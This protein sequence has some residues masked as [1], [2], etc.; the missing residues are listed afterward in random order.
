L[1]ILK[2][3]KQ[4]GTLYHFTTID[5]FVDIIFSEN[6]ISN[7]DLEGKNWYFV[8]FGKYPSYEE[9]RSWVEDMPKD[10]N[11]YHSLSFT[12]DK[13]L[14]KNVHYFN[15]RRIRF[16]FD[17]DKIS[18]KYRIVPFTDSNIS[19]DEMEEAV[20]LKNNE[21]FPIL[22]YLISIELLDDDRDLFDSKG[23]RVIREI[24]KTLDKE[25]IPFNFLKNWYQKI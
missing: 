7:R 5:N 6:L 11:F 10:K 21:K 15:N 22:P 18:N 1:R 19:K 25:G 3:G 24:L 2:E 13:A 9:Y 20:V 17:G 16:S 14:Q 4:V 12:R 8:Q 23:D